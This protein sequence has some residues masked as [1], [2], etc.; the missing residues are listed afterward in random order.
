M[1]YITGRVFKFTAGYVKYIR[2]AR[3]AFCNDALYKLTF[4]FTSRSIEYNQVV[5]KSCHWTTSF[6]LQA[7]MTGSCRQV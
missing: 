6:S 3:G 1:A 7:L 2:G 5:S 4:T